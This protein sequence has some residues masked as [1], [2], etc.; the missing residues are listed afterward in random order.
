MLPI[1]ALYPSAAFT[2]GGALRC[3][4]TLLAQHPVRGLAPAV[5]AQRLDELVLSHG[6]RQGSNEHMAGLNSSPALECAAA[7]K[8]YDCGCCLLLPTQRAAALRKLRIPYTQALHFMI[9]TR[10]L[11]V[12]AARRP[13]C[14]TLTG[15]SL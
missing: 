7:A 6:L 11:R 15:R 2:V 5:A 12:P 3:A 8:R 4:V 1:A 14:H 13:P 9:V 10:V